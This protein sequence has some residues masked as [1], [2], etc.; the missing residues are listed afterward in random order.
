[1]SI[2]DARL[3]KGHCSLCLFCM[4]GCSRDTVHSAA[5]SGCTRDT[6]HCVSALERIYVGPFSVREEWN[7]VLGSGGVF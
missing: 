2:L 4:L 1:M 7:V 6:V 3:Y 5:V